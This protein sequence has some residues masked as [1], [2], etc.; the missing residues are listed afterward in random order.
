MQGSAHFGIGTHIA[1]H[2]IA[3]APVGDSAQLLFDRFER[4]PGLLG[5]KL[6]AHRKQGGK[7]P[8][9]AREVHPLEE[10]LTPV[11]LEVHEQGPLPRAPPPASSRAPRVPPLTARTPPAAPPTP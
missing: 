8:H 11:A 10:L 4:L 1:Q 9:R 5:L 3:D 7:P 2:P 6:Q